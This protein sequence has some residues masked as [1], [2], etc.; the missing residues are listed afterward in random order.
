MT[1]G[2]GD[3][4]ARLGSFQRVIGSSMVLCVDADIAL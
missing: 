2:S 3:D 4:E 1:K